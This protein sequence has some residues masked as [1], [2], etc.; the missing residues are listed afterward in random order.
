MSE[1]KKHPSSAIRIGKASIS[2]NILNKQDNIKKSEFKIKSKRAMTAKYQKKL[3]KNYINSKESDD[4]L[5][6]YIK[7]QSNINENKDKDIKDKKDDRNNKKKRIKTKRRN[8]FIRRRK[9]KK[10]RKRKKI[11]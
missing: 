8:A 4:R 2:K 6:L 11:N 3:K 10:K 9:T 5:N 7:D 1:N